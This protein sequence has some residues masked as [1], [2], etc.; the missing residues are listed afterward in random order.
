MIDGLFVIPVP[1][2]SQRDVQ[3][4]AHIRVVWPRATHLLPGAAIDSRVQLV[5]VLTVL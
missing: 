2:L 5:S 4:K 1:N 3:T